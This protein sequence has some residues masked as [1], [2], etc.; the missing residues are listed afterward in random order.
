MTF[1]T[2]SSFFSKVFA[3]LSFLVLRASPSV[4]VAP[5]HSLKSMVDDFLLG[6]QQGG[7]SAARSPHSRF[8]AST[9]PRHERTRRASSSTA[10][11]ATW[12]AGR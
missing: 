9:R 1:A 10:R 12:S 6:R 4:A 7:R 5:R 3:F 2:I 8:V 11:G